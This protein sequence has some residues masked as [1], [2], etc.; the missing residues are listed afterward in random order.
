VDKSR[1]SSNIED[2]LTALYELAPPT[3]GV[4]TTKLATFMGLSAPSVSLMMRRLLELGLVERHADGGCVL[5]EAGTRDALSVLRRH[6]LSECFLVQKLGLDWAQAHIEAHRFEHS[7]SD[8]VTDAL[9]RFLGHPTSCPHGHPIPDRLG[10]LPAH[11]T[12]ALSTATTGDRLRVAC[13]N[14]ESADLLGWF[15]QI[16]LVPGAEIRVGSVDAYGKSMLLELNGSNIPIGADVAR[17]VQVEG[18]GEHVA[19]DSAR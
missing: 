18:I 17:T 2:Y 15:Q 6:R 1:L 9:E 19:S 5:S 7:L 10:R 11:P 13:V 4:G 3:G 12:T 14:D 16:G 8:E